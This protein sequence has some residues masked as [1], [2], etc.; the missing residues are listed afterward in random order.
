MARDERVLIRHGGPFVALAS[1]ERG[2]TLRQYIIAVAVGAL[3]AIVVCSVFAERIY[4]GLL[5]AFAP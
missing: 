5:E 2:Q 3:L 4:F 1:D